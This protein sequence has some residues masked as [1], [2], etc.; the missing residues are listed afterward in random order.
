MSVFRKALNLTLGNT[1]DLSYLK[2]PKII[3]SAVKKPTKREL[4]QQESEIGRELF[5][6]IPEGHRREFFNLDPVTWIW[7][8]EYPGKDGKMESLTTRYEI[9]QAGI[10]KAQGSARY[11]YI[12]GQ[13]LDNLLSA[14]RLYYDRVMR[15]IYHRNP[16]TGQKTV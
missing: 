8:E 9:Q 1:N 15:Q 5:G 4:I 3:P 6:P 16:T 10:L 2:M 11:T 14:I 13:E 7:Y 12:E